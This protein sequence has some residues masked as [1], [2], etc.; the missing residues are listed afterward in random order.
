MI[1]VKANATTVWLHEKIDH[2]HEAWST[3]QKNL[4]GIAPALAMHVPSC[5]TALHYL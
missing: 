2:K 4:L 1:A 3:K 5:R